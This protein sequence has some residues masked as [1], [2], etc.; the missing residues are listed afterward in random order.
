VRAAADTLTQMWRLAVGFRVSRALGVAV[1]LGI[2]EFLAR[3]PHTASQLA[4]DTRTHEPSLLRLLRLLVVVDV[5]AEDDQGRFSLTPLG[6]ELR[7]DRFGPFAR[8]M[9]GEVDW[10]VW[11]HLDHSIR[12]GE[13]AF[14]HAF[15]MRNWEYY[16]AH[17]A[18]GAIFDAA[19]RAL[20]EPVAE[21]VASAYDFS[22]AATVADVGGGDGT[23]LIAILKHHPSLR[24]VLFDR[25]NVVERAR[26]RIEESGLG[27]RAEVVGGSFFK[28]VPADADIYLMKSI[29]HD[30]SDEDAVAIMKTVRS[31]AA[32]GG[33]PLL[34]VERHL[35]ERVGPDD[36]DAVLSDLNMLVNPGGRE[37]T[38]SEYAELLRAAAYGLN[39]TVPL[40]F[41][42]QILEG[43]PV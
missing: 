8:F 42:F 28:E 9:D 4:A 15:G 24:G 14:D 6:E 17:P 30:W 11:Q 37:R 27:G 3:H 43:L 2:P 10:R 35:S 34:L 36:I 31:A 29:V 25:P 7:A 23:M 5:L 21:A 41:G 40:G 1:E 16:A 18:D 13:R 32:A 26:R 39:R 20:T 22:H 12:T 38:D 19:M 33:S